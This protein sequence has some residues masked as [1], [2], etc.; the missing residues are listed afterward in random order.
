MREE[1]SCRS[2]LDR[3]SRQRQRR[4]KGDSHAAACAT[5]THPLAKSWHSDHLKCGMVGRVETSGA[6][7]NRQGFPVQRPRMTCSPLNRPWLPM[8]DAG[9]LWVRL[10]V[11]FARRRFADEF[12]RFARFVLSFSSEIRRPLKYGESQAMADDA[13]LLRL[14]DV[15]LVFAA[16]GDRPAVFRPVP[17]YRRR[18][19]ALCFR[20]WL[21]LHEFHLKST[22]APRARR[23]P[24]MKGRVTG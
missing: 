3:S 7:A 6:M 19:S 14:L 8:E 23:V 11:P 9:S 18:N 4:G 22:Q 21:V 1:A 24:M 17:G 20:E 15:D 13:V 10:R 5:A 12:E 16:L 2:T